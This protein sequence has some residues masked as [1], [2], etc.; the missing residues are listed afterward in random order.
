MDGWQRKLITAAKCFAARDISLMLTQLN[1][2]Q[3][4]LADHASKMESAVKEII[5]E[6]SLQHENGQPWLLA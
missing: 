6:H 3:N 4:L 2:I 5:L 1:H